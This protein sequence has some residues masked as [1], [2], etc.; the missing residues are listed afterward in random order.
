MARLDIHRLISIEMIEP[1]D[2]EET[3]GQS[4]LTE[5]EK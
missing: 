4:Q 2:G 5:K 3:A 1:I